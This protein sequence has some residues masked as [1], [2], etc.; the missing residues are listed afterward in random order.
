MKTGSPQIP[1]SKRAAGLVLAAAVALVS[2][3]V[4]ANAADKLKIGYIGTFSGPGAAF[5]QNM[6]DGFMLGLEELGGKLGG[7]EVELSKNDDQWKPDVAK[8]IAEKLVTRDHVDIV[9][10]VYFSNI[11]VSIYRTVVDS[12]T[13]LITSNAGPSPQAGKECSPYFFTTSWQS[14][15]LSKALGKYMSDHGLNRVATV[16]SNYQAGVD[17]LNGFKS[18]FKGTIV[19]EIMPA[20]GQL[21][22]SAEI[23]RVSSQKPDAIFAF[24]AGGLSV[25]FVKQYAQAGLMK[26]IPFHSIFTISATNLPAIGEVAIGT[27]SI[28]A[29]TIDADNP[30][31]KKFVENF[32]KKYK[33]DPSIDSANAY[34]SVFLIDQAVRDINGK[35]E[36]KQAFIRALEQAKFKSIRGTFKFN[37]NHFPIQTFY[38]TAVT[39]ASDGH[40][41]DAR[42]EAVLVDD[43]DAYHDQCKMN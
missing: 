24:I 9:A 10:G 14:D 3:G 35:I 2:L 25:N 37:N 17:A 19:A 29:W 34:D 30:E 39:K 32:R 40:L 36:D 15:Q 26:K 5:G 12:N 42:G 43:M 31:N 18:G 7:L 8:Q 27:K 41:Y 1:N 23:A 22:Y 20:V 28:N 13:L 21:D 6:A 11:L 38:Q 33:R 4:P 16:V